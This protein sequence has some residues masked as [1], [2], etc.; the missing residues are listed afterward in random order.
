MRHHGNRVARTT[1]D[2]TGIGECLDQRFDLGLIGNLVLDVAADG[3][4][5]IALT[6]LV[7]DV[8]QFTQG[9]DI[10]NTLC[11]CTYCPDLVTVS[12]YM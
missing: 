8:T 2:V 7:T 1:D 6:I 9:E 12:G 4:V 5:D 11:A 3:E 10:E